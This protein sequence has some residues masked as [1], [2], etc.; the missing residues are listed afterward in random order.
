MMPKIYTNEEKL[1]A[2]ERE[3]RYRERVYGR[4]VTLGKMTAALKEEQI[5][6]FEA[7]RDDYKALVAKEQ[8]L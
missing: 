6:I 2:V 5:A 4:R 3:L 8:L 1:Q 7:I